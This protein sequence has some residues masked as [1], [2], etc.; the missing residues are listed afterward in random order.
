V[1]KYLNADFTVFGLFCCHFKRNALNFGRGGMLGNQL[2]YLHFFLLLSVTFSFLLTKA[3]TRKM[4]EEHFQSQSGRLAHLEM[5]QC[6]VKFHKDGCFS[7]LC[8]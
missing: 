4:L 1:A 6:P 5:K 3:F 8:I 7:A 2:L